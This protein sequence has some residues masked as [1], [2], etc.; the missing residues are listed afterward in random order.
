MRCFLFKKVLV[1]EKLPINQLITSKNAWIYGFAKTI[2]RSKNS[3]GVDIYSLTW[4]QDLL[5]CL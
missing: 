3:I 1:G 2:L 5:Y 4:G